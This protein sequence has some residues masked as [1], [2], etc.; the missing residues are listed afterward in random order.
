MNEA[1][2]YHARLIDP[3]TLTILCTYTCTAACRQCCFESSP[4]VVGRLEREALLDRIK[5][6][7]SKFQNLK[8]VVFSGGEATLLKEDLYEAVALCTSLGLLTRIVSNG[9]WGKTERSANHV[10]S[11]LAAS[12]LSELNISTGK[13]HQEFVSQDCVINAAQAVTGCMIPTLI[14][15]EADEEK[16]RHYRHLASDPRVQKLLREGF[17]RIQS[18]SWMPFHNDADE[19]GQ[20]ID[21][22]SLRNGCDQIFSNVVVTPHDNLS[23]CCGLTLEHIPEMRLGRCDGSNMDALY[24]SQS[25][26]FLKFWIHTDGPYAIIESVLGKESAKILDGV[27]HICQ[28]CA[29]LHKDDEVKRAVLSRYQQLAPEV[30]TRFYLKRALEVSSKKITD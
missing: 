13:D 12:R 28:A 8:I 15:V 1:K 23:A 2:A 5:E 21:H 26:D 9:S 10:A 14:A 16:N 4:K 19:R 17:L 24:Y 20:E 25:Q 27:V 18:N 3:Q 30:M 29:I 7:K 11:K 22:E 6:A